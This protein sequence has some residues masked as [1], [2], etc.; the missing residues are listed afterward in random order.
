[1]INKPT[2]NQWPAAAAAPHGAC[3]EAHRPPSRALPTALIFF[4]LLILFYVA[5]LDFFLLPF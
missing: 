4:L 3:A 2:E 1:M 5:L